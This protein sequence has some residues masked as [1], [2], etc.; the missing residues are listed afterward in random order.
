MSILGSLDSNSSQ[1]IPEEPI[2]EFDDLFQP[3]PSH[4]MEEIG[5]I[6][7]PPPQIKPAPVV[8][9]TV[10]DKT[11]RS[12]STTERPI[13]IELPLGRLKSTSLIRNQF[14]VKTPHGYIRAIAPSGV[15]VSIND[16]VIVRDGPVLVYG[17]V[18]PTTDVSNKGDNDGKTTSISYTDT[19]TIMFVDDSH[20]LV[21]SLM[22]R[23]KKASILLGLIMER[24]NVDFEVVFLETVSFNN[25]AAFHMG[26]KS[27]KTEA[28]QNICRQLMYLFGCSV[29]P[30]F[31]G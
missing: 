8:T 11:T 24:D 25:R 17:T 12:R 26:Y 29:I 23:D 4:L 31:I 27:T 18:V 3:L 5:I 9:P 6:S 10:V 13:S 2:F 30:I 7:I 20:V 21:A 1:C 15:V 19:P 14:V 22:D 16:H 28:V